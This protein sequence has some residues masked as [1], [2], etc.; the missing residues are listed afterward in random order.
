[1]FSFYMH[2]A[3]VTGNENYASISYYSELLGLMADLYVH[4][5]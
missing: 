2:I 3:F 4:V 5:V 1:M